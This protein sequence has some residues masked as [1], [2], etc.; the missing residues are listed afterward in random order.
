MSNYKNRKRNPC[1]LGKDCNCYQRVLEEQ[2]HPEEEPE[3]VCAN[4]QIYYDIK[5]LPEDVMDA[6]RESG[7]EE[8]WK[9][10]PKMQFSVSNNEDVANH[11]VKFISRYGKLPG[12]APMMKSI[13]VH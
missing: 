3:C 2:F 11:V 13:H 6:I 9:N 5:N 4:T 8:K 1:A 10:I 12:V 7:L